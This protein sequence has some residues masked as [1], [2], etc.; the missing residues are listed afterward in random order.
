MTP[1]LTHR[2]V[3]APFASLGVALIPERREWWRGGLVDSLVRRR[4]RITA[5]PFQI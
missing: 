4:R 2:P 1:P 5:Q 3:N